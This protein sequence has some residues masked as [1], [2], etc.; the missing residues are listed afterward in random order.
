M[1]RG[2]KN[3]PPSLEVVFTPCGY[4]HTVFIKRPSESFN[5]RISRAVCS[6]DH[7]HKLMALT[8]SGWFAHSANT[9]IKDKIDDIASDIPENSK[10]ENLRDELAVYR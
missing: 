4:C 7:S 10:F 2:V 6:V 3:V 1:T 8:G 9:I 5:R